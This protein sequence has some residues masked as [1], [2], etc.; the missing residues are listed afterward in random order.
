LRLRTSKKAAAV[1]IS[2]TNN[3]VATLN[4]FAP[5]RA[6]NMDTDSSGTE[7][8]T[9]EETVPGKAGKPPPIILTSVSNLN[10]L[11]RQLKNVV[12]SDYEFRNTQKTEP[13]SSPKA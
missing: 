9:L 6:T 4:F 10:Q 11:Q 12:K 1:A 2:I 8:T 13:E 3:E 5:L 7:A